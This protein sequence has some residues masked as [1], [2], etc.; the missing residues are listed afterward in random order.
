M[1]AIVTTPV[2]FVNEWEQPQNAAQKHGACGARAK[3]DDKECVGHS[4]HLSKMKT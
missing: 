4:G 2:F 3:Y 1:N